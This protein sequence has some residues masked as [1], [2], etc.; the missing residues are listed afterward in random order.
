VNTTGRE[1]NVPAGRFLSVP[2]NGN[3]VSATL[4][5]DELIAFAAQHIARYKKP[6]FVEL[7]DS[8]PKTASGETDR[9]AVKAKH[10]G[11]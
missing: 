11:L 3:G 10:G 8:L 4:T 2:L 7:V 1:V 9:A 5:A 6:K